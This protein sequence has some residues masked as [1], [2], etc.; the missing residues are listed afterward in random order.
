MYLMHDF[1]INIF[2]IILK[3]LMH[4]FDIFLHLIALLIMCFNC[5]PFVVLIPS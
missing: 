1:G 4:D 5:M 3:Y 2:G